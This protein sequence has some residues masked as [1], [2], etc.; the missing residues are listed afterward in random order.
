MKNEQPAK[1]KKEAKKEVNEV[2]KETK[3]VSKKVKATSVV[4]PQITRP[5]A[6]PV[7]DSSY[8]LRTAE[9]SFDTEVYDEGD[10]ASALELGFIA[11]ALEMHKAKVAPETHPNFDGETCVDCGDDIPEV[12]LTM[13]KV[14]CVHCQELLEKKNK[15]RG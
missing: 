13:G 9:L 5:V 10:I 7:D 15:L 3:K 11:H 8:S 2:N 1:P 12:R 14:R 6:P 4:P